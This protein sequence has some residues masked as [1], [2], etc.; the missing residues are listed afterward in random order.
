MGSKV[1]LDFKQYFQAL[2]LNKA[3]VEYDFFTFI[4]FCINSKK[5]LGACD[6]YFWIESEDI[7]Q[8]FGYKV[9][10]NIHTGIFLDRIRGYYSNFWI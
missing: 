8:T 10:S 5:Y 9:S 1:E 2:P 4:Y 7:L 3:L 6:W